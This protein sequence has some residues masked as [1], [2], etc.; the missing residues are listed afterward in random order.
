MSEDNAPND[1][2]GDADVREDIAEQP[3]KDALIIFNNPEKKGKC[4]LGLEDYM[5]NS[6]SRILL[7][8]MPGC[9]K[10]NLIFNILHRMIPPPSVVHLVHTDADC[11]EYDHIS[12]MGIPLLVYTP[13]NFPTI[14][15][16]D[17]PFGE[18][19][20][21]PT[22]EEKKTT[23]KPLQNPLVIVDEVTTDALGRVGCH[24]FERLVNP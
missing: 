17:D 24:R 4:R 9:G 6:T 7:S 23:K 21:E 14:Q 11:T 10:R 8:A 2:D 15:N 12:E 22:D 13:D 5:P 20:V 18:E 19:E 3:P 16:I 1:S